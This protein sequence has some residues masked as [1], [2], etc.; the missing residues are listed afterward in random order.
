M[1]EL[2]L[3]S[4]LVKDLPNAAIIIIIA[5]FI[6]KAI[7]VVSAYGIIRFITQKTHDAIINPKRKEVDIVE[8]LNKVTITAATGSLVEQV[9]RIQKDNLHYIHDADVQWLKE[10]I[11]E[12][13]ER[14]RVKVE[15]VNKRP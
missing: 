10:A 7:I 8:S 11:D 2:K 5:Y 12:K 15:P 1:E 4:G 13:E 3:L 14:E 9:M 6:Y